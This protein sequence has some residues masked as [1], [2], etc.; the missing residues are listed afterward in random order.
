MQHYRATGTAGSPGR[1][2]RR[3]IMAGALIDLVFWLLVVGIIALLGS[4]V[5]KGLALLL[6]AQ[7]LVG[8]RR[9]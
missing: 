4:P 2:G 3:N 1:S 5:G 9:G 8:G 7:W 6:V